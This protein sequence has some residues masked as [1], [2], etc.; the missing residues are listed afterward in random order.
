[1]GGQA[2]VGAVAHHGGPQIAAG[3]AQ[4]P[5][6]HGARDFVGADADAL[7]QLTTVGCGRR[8]WELQREGEGTEDQGGGGGAAI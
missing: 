3:R 6:D 2:E 5:G 7:P 8:G 1:V 4:G